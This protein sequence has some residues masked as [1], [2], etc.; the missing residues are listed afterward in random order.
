VIPLWSQGLLPRFLLL[1]LLLLFLSFFFSTLLVCMSQ[2]KVLKY[3]S[4]EP[5]PLGLSS[6]NG[7]STGR[8]QKKKE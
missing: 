8:E 6:E 4:F 7:V 3:L 5:F 2:S 1:L